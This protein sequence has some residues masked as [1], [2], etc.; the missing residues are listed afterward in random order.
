MLLYAGM[1]VLLVFVIR[2]RYRTGEEWPVTVVGVVAGVLLIVG[3]VP[4]PFEIGKRRGRVVGIDFWFLAID[5][6][7]AFFSLMAIGMCI[8]NYLRRWPLSEDQ[9]VDFLY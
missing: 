2:E 3:Y 4:V 8:H 7:G 9:S 1:E 5:W 6:S